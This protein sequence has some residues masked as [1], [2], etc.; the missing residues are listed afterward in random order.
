MSFSYRKLADV[1]EGWKPPD[2]ETYYKRKDWNIKRPICNYADSKH[3]CEKQA[4][5]WWFIHNNRCDEHITP[6]AKR[7]FYECW[8]RSRFIL[9][10]NS[11]RDHGMIS[12]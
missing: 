10:F 11:L 3:T 1:P 12:I 9:L 4:T 6:Y 2:W 8:R 5:W 7:W